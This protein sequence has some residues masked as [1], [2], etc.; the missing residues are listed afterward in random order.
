MIS[1]SSEDFNALTYTLQVFNYFAGVATFVPSRIKD[2]FRKFSIALSG[3][4]SSLVA[5]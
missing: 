2:L 4:R 1:S 5:I 3:N